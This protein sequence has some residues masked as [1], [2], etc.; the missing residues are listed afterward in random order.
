MPLIAIWRPFDTDWTRDQALPFWSMIGAEEDD[1]IVV[2][3]GLTVGF[4]FAI[5][6]H[7]LFGVVSEYQ[8]PLEFSWTIAPLRVSSSTTLAVGVSTVP[9]TAICRPFDAD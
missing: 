7:E 3:L 8:L 2:P 1:L 5:C 9:F 4:G 6:V